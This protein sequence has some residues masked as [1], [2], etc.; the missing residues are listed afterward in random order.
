[1]VIGHRGPRDL[2]MLWM[3]W[4]RREPPSI[5][6]HA[7]VATTNDMARQLTMLRPTRPNLGGSLLRTELPIMTRR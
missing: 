6:A 1:M 2:A 5:G 7:T 4:V 3:E